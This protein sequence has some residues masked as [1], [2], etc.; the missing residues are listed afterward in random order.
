MATKKATTPEQTTVDLEAFIAQH[1]RAAQAAGLVVTAIS[2]P[3]AT[4]RLH[5]G[6]YSGFPITT[7]ELSATYSDGS[8]H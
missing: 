8:T 5:P 7:G 2:Y 1:E 4:P 3:G 6:V